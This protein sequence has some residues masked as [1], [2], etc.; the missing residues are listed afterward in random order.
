MRNIALI[1]LACIALGC[2]VR[3]KVLFVG[4][5]NTVLTA[6]DLIAAFW[7]NGVAYEP[8]FPAVSGSGYGHALPLNGVPGWAPALAQLDGDAVVLALGLNDCLPGPAGTNYQNP[9]QYAALID[10]VID[11]LPPSAPIV[12]VD[13]PYVT[14]T[15]YAFSCI[16][17]V[18][19]ALQAATARYAPRTT[20]L[21]VNNVINGVSGA[22]YVD[23]VHYSPAVRAAVAAAIRNKVSAVL[24]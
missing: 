1:L 11:S 18:N 13:A 12:L 2:D 20:Y 10:T 21:N 8:S 4:D 24:P 17:N 3:G 15:S 7:T 5:S 14:S 22:K 19:L 6:P 23:G 16:V 9:T